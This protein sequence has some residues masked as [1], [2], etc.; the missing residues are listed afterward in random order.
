M[1]LHGCF[2]ALVALA[3][4][5]PVLG[6]ELPPLPYLD[7]DA[8]PF[9]CGTYRDWRARQT[10]I[11]YVEPK[12]GSPVAFTIKNK[13]VVAAETGFVQTLKAGITKVMKPILLGYEKETSDPEPK[14]LLHLKPGE[15]LYTL[16]YVGE[17]SDLFWYQGKVY[18]DQIASDK[19]DP[20]PP[21]PELD[22]QVLSRPIAV[23]WVKV[24]T[25]NG[26]IGWLKN[27][28]YFENSDACS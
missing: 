18:T 16:H 4:A 24:M 1:N 8:C 19:P 17:G 13:Q 21:P 26:R 14:P 28:P 5:V 27:P 25:K 2:V 3:V 11:A 22:L 9:E 23:W 10:V 15:L 6:Q 20:N 7:Q 12:D